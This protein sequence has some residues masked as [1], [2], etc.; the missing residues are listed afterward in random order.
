MHESSTNDFGEL[1]CGVAIDG[2]GGR[3]TVGMMGTHRLDNLESRRRERLDIDPVGR[4]GR[5]LLYRLKGR[6]VH[7]NQLLWEGTWQRRGRVST[8]QV[9][10]DYAP[11]LHPALSA[12]SGD[13]TGRRSRIHPH[14]SS[15]ASTPT[16]ATHHTAPPAPIGRSI[17]KKERRPKIPQG[18]GW[19][20]WRESTHLSGLGHT[21]QPGKARGLHTTRSTQHHSVSVSVCVCVCVCVERQTDRQCADPTHINLLCGHQSEA[22]PRRSTHGAVGEKPHI[23]SL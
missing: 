21:P 15:R 22:T 11:C 5:H 6:G 18:K 1:G 12:A 19:T 7:G 10:S 13:R 9:Y 16:R 17:E 23:C 2:H 4:G 8:V 20:G 3:V 14:P